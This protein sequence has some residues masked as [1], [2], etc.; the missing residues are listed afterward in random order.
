MARVAGRQ[1]VTVRHDTGGFERILV[2]PAGGRLALWDWPY[3]EPRPSIPHPTLARAIKGAKIGE[4]RMYLGPGRCRSVSIEA[5]EPAP[6]LHRATPVRGPRPL[7]SSS[8]R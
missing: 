5:I 2:D 8:G 6:A 3:L 4:R 7:G 1:V